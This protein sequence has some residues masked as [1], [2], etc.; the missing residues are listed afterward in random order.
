MTTRFIGIKELQ[1]DLSQ[2]LREAQEK[3][4][5]FVIMRHNEPIAEFVPLKQKDK[6]LRR[7]EIVLEELYKEI[8]QAREEVK[9]GEVYTEEEIAEEFGIAL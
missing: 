3:R 9:R 8:A 5:H 6:K 7:K 4:I 2:I 1:R